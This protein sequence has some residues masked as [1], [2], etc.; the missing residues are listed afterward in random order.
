MKKS[1]FLF[2]LTLSLL[3]PLFMQAQGRLFTLED[4][5]YG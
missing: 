2:L 3:F 4:L 1:K 5:N